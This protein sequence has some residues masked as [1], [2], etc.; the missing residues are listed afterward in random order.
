MMYDLKVSD[1]EK[2]ILEL[3]YSCKYLMDEIIQECLEDETKE[4]PWLN[5]EIIDDYFEFAGNCEST[6]KNIITLHGLKLLLNK[7]TY[8]WI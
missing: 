1:N 6:S 8:I 7:T 2:E 4:Y 3:I 5:I